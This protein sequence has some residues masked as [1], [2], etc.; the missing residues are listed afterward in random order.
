MQ[1]KHKVFLWC[2]CIGYFVLVFGEVQVRPDAGKVFKVYTD[3]CVSGFL[4]FCSTVLITTGERI[5]FWAGIVL[6]IVSIAA[7]FLL[8]HTPLMI[9]HL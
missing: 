1:L 5:A 8:D 6:W 2:V 4:F 9:I 7:I 3:G